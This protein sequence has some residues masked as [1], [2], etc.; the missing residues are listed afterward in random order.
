MEVEP[1]KGEMERGR[2]GDEENE[3]EEREEPQMEK[4]MRSVLGSDLDKFDQGFT[5][6]RE[7]VEPFGQETGVTRVVE[8][9]LHEISK[10]FD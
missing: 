3:D 4:A 8:D 2:E 9:D 10:L 7:K 6:E 5:G 1:E